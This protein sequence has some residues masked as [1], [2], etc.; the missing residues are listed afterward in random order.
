MN[1]A[2]EITASADGFRLIAARFCSIVSAASM[3]ERTEFLVQIYRILSEL[4]SAAIRLP[5]VNQTDEEQE[6]S[7]SKPPLKARLSHEQWKQLYDLLKEKIGDWDIYWQVFDPTNDK[8][9]V[10]GSLADDIAD[11]YRDLKEGLILLE[12][13]QTPTEDIVWSWRLLYYSHWGKHAIDTLLALH[14]RLQ[15]H[16]E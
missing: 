9:A 15:Y 6:A 10:A 13:H 16:L 2:N 7:S 12:G 8:H 5:E 1:S 14:F 11:I 3:L 4:I